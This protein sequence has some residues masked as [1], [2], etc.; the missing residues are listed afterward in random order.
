[1][2]NAITQA[3][4]E[5]LIFLLEQLFEA[6]KA[7]AAERNKQT[8]DRSSTTPGVHFW[9]TIEAKDLCA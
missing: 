1:M 9:R 7:R 5:E 4:V 6:R 2:L 8:P 3:Q